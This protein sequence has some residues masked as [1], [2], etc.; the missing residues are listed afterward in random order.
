MRQN[1]G[2][3]NGRDSDA[4]SAPVG[5]PAPTGAHAQRIMIGVPCGGEGRVT[6]RQR[7][8]A[9]LSGSIALER[10]AMDAHPRAMY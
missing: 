10:Q 4:W 9:H 8:E 7:V 5:W 3:S 2:R 6:R 1:R